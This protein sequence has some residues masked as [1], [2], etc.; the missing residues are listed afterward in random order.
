[1]NSTI[2]KIYYKSPIFIQNIAVTL[3]GWK[4]YRERFNTEGKE[5]LLSLLAS[6]TFTHKKIA[7][8]QDSMFTAIARHAINT[9]PYYQAWAKKQS[10]TALDINSLA[11][12]KHFPIID[13][14]FLRENAALFKSD[15]LALTKHQFTLNTSGTTGTPLTV[16]TDQHS[17]SKHYAFFTRLRRSYGVTDSD[18]R[19]TLFGRI[20]L[21]ADQKKPPFWRYDAMQH[22]LLMSSYHLSDAN[23]PYYY[24]KLK[25]FKPQEIFAYP[26]SIYAIANFIVRNQLEPI[27]LKLIMTTAENLLPQQRDIIKAAFHAPIVNQ[28]GCTEMAFFCSDF[29]DGNMK[30]HPEHGFAEVQDKDGVI[31]DSGEGDL[32]ATGFINF[33]M[34]VIRYLVGDRINLSERDT[35]GRQVLSEVHGRTDDIIYRKDGTPVGRL[36]PIFKGGSGILCAQIIQ[37]ADAS[38]ILKLVRDNNY[39]P[40]NGDELILE[41]KKRL[42]S[43]L[44]ITLELVDDI[45]KEKNGKFRPVICNYKF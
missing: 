22:N 33:S 40:N 19:A 43:E 44:P 17:R 26:S 27:R 16:Y 34:P 3:F 18:K 29:P 36:D 21:T 28:Y 8:L 41:L 9:T 6:E 25:H 32:L 42:G 14:K 10:I 31:R 35:Q 30:F 20:I 13:K 37:N 2:E 45:A 15:D 39:Q 4:L 12:I 24:E 23:I 5:M 7:Q 11:D 1:M 38:V